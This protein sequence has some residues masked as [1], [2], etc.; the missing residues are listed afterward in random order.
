MTKLSKQTLARRRQR[1]ALLD[2]ARAEMRK[3]DPG[4][5]ARV[6]AILITY[7]TNP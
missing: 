7:V 4:S 5:P 6:E 3:R 1:R 2:A